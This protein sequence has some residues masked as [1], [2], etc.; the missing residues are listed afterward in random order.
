MYTQLLNNAG[1]FV[2]LA[3]AARTAT[4][5][6]D[7]QVNV[8]YNGV[9]ISIVVSAVTATPS[10]VPKIQGKDAS[11]NYYD[12]LVGAAITGTGTTVL[13][14]FPNATDATNL[15]ANDFIPKNWRI[16][17]THGDTDSI[18]YSVNTN[19]TLV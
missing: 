13:R 9:H 15:T 5:T 18:T 6:S 1:S 8:D 7:D 17:M 3:S 4:V 19:T 10:V 14:V 16:V 12:I 2:V 11:G